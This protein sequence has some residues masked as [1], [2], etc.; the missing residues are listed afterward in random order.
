M[1]VM[2]ALESPWRLTAFRDIAGI[3]SIP[4]TESL[5]ETRDA[6]FDGPSCFRIVDTSLATVLGGRIHDILPARKGRG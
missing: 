3:W 1:I 2:I 6:L 5:R 4:K